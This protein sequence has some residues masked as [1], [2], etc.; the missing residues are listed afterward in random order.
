MRVVS[1]GLCGF[2]LQCFDMA[3]T[4]ILLVIASDVPSPSVLIDTGKII[5]LV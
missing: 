4:S 2:C 3:L 1:S 5:R